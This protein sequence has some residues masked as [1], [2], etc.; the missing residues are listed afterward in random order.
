MTLVL[1]T[2]PICFLLLIGEIEI[3]PRLYAKI[4]APPAVLDELSHAEAPEEVRIW[5][6]TPPAWLAI[7]R[8]APAVGTTLHFLDEGEREA[9]RL[10]LELED[11][12]LVLDD[13]IAR[14]EARKLG[15]EVTGLLGLLI[16]A[17]QG[18]LLDLPSA[19]ARLQ[20]TH[21]YVSPSLIRSLLASYGGG[22]GGE[23]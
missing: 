6:A 1:D 5:A 2:S 20:Q 22:T 4:A 7:R 23:R 18:G 8:A 3:L 19:L 13:R 16:R 9:I 15:L 12:L 11:S 21:F 17:G 10:A 14:E